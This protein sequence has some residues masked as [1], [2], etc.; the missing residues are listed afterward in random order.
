M[1]RSFRSKALKRF[2]ESGD[3]SKLSVRNVLRV[4]IMLSHL[5]SARS[6][7]ELNLP[8]F[9]F[10]ALRG[11]DKGRFSIRVTGNYHLTFGWAEED[12]IDVD[13]EDYH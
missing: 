4:T 2:A 12:A 3:A 7:E 8:G 5:E 11:Q 1:I 6:P 10:H 9:Y 13:L